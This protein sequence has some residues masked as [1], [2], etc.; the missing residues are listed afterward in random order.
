M[1]PRRWLVTE[2]LE[3]E[4]EDI[5]TGSRAEWAVFACGPTEML[6]TVKVLSAEKKIRAFLS[7]EN[8][9]ACGFGVC[10][11]C[12]VKVAAPGGYQH[13]RVCMEGPVFSSEE[14]I[15]DD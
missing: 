13:V 4:I 9:M 2:V 10:L 14:V 5:G 12:V 11:G 7:L 6:S 15:F 3:K 1:P 8:F